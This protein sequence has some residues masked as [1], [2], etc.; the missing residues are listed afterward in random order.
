MGLRIN[1]NIPAL[2]ANRQT[3]QANKA[4]TNALQKLGSGLRINQAADDAAGLAIS[5]RFRT[6]IL[7]GQQEMNNLQTGVNYA[8]TADAGLDVQQ[9]ATQRIRELA[10]QASNGTLTQDQRNALNAEAQQL[11]GQIDDVAQN[12]QYNGQ[13]MLNANTTTPL[14]TEG[15]AQVTVNQSDTAALGLTG[16]DLS[17]A[18][19]ATAALNNVDTALT[20]IDQNRAGLGAQMNRFESNINQLQNSVMNATNAESMIRDADIARTVMDRT[21]N[22]IMQQGGIAAILQGNV[23]QRSALALLRG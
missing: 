20:R 2:G 15:G 7:Q 21:R 22:Q 17:T 6:K 14:G 12:T 8:Q 11:M 23:A 1:S 18:A 19:G 3:E 10:V 13:A 4:L 16:L 5:E 9:Q